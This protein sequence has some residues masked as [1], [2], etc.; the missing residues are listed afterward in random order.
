MAVLWIYGV[1]LIKNYQSWQERAAAS[2]VILF[3]TLDHVML[4]KNHYR[5]SVIVIGVLI[6]LGYLSARASQILF[7]LA[8]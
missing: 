2:I 7:Q 3:S 8:F 6:R 4:L 5:V 1:S